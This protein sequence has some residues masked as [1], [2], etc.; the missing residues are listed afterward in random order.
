MDNEDLVVVLGEDFSEDSMREILEIF[1][2]HSSVEV[3]VG[4]E[5]NLDLVQISVKISR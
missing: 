3:W 2:H 1:S 4:E 5:A